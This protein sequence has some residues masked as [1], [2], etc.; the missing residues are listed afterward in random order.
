LPT[1]FLNK[2]RLEN[3]KNVK[4]VKKRFYIYVSTQGTLQ[5]YETSQ[6]LPMHASV[7]ALSVITS[8]HL[9]DNQPGPRSHESSIQRAR[10]TLSAEH[11]NSRETSKDAVFHNFIII[12]FAEC[13]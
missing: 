13:L 4:N 1:F 8:K 9:A 2:K 7:R 12:S 10:P 5:E 11:G 6:S 3:K